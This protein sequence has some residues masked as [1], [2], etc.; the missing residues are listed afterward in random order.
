[1]ELFSWVKQE[2]FDLLQSIGIVLGLAFTALA[3]KA[4]AKSRRIDNLLTITQN[5]REIWT[6]HF[7]HPNFS[8]VLD[9]NV[10]LKDFPV[11]NEE[12]IFV[13]FL[14]LHLSSSF[15]AKQ[16]GILI[17]LDGVRDDIRW[18]FSLPIP[19]TIWEKSKSFQNKDFVLF[20][21]SC[22]Y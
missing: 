1:M 21:D 17:N 4:D 16:N 7:S 9:S 14:L 20:V 11:T 15:Y 22:L 8:R 5:Q 18:I 10:N 2:W 12:A 13:T 3:L 19:K 6:L